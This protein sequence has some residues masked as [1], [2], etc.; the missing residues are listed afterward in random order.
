M[1]EK[2]E[3]KGSPKTGLPLARNKAILLQEIDGELLIYDLDT[4]KAY[5][6]NKTAAL[7]WQLCDGTKSVAQISIEMSK[8]L[9]KQVST[10]LVE[11]ALDSLKKD[12]LLEDVDGINFLDGLS[13]REAIRKVG[14]AS[15]VAL[16]IVSSLVAPK[17]VAAQSCSA[18]NISCT[19]NSD[20]CSGQ[21]YSAV[22]GT[23]C[24][25]NQVTGPGHPPGTVFACFNSSAFCTGAGIN[26]CCSGLAFIDFNNS[27][28]CPVNTFQCPCS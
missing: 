5:N 27:T 12:G 7:V 1:I 20:C 2:L 24:C 3:G 16:P 18:N 13:R 21:C 10:E 19:L 23:V 4:D 15:I 25:N 28:G 9:R 22:A 17:A 8:L 6:L 11:L 14:F 26:A